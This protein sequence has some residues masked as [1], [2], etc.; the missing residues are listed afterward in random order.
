MHRDRDLHHDLAVPLVRP[1]C[2]TSKKVAI[3]SAAAVLHICV[4]YSCQGCLQPVMLVPD[5]STVREVSG[6]RSPQIDRWRKWIGPQAK[7][8]WYFAR[9]HP[10]KREGL[11][12]HV[13]DL[14]RHDSLEICAILRSMCSLTDRMAGSLD[15]SQI[16]TLSARAPFDHLL[17]AHC[18]N[19]FL[20]LGWNR[21]VAALT[22]LMLRG[23]S[24]SAKHSSAKKSD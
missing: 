17:S 15:L 21:H 9:R 16:S 13:S 10:P 2:D 11:M 1:L 7:I 23:W 4:I 24:L 22:D 14:V 3:T 12:H 6:C 20:C 18:V 19:A 8:W 5:T